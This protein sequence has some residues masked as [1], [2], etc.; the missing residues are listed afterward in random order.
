MPARALPTGSSCLAGLSTAGAATGLDC[1]AAMSSTGPVMVIPAITAAWQDT[2]TPGPPQGDGEEASSGSSKE[3]YRIKGV[4]TCRLGSLPS[5]SCVA[6][7]TLL[8][9]LRGPAGCNIGP[10]GPP[11]QPLAYLI[12]SLTEVS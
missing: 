6:I 9:G 8:G 4:P 1:P 12:A 10:H 5:A 7:L 11:D 2:P 3:G